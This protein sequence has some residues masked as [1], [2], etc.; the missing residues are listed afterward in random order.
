MIKKFI[1]IILAAIMAFTVFSACDNNP[2]KADTAKEDTKLKIVTTIF[3]QYDFSREIAGDLADLKMLLPPGSESH[4]F[5]PTPQDIID[6]ENCDIFIYTGGESDSW[7]DTILESI[8]APDMKVIALLDVCDAVTEEIVEGMEH[9]ED[10]HSGSP[11]YDEHVWT[12]PKNAITIVEA[13]AEAFAQADAENAE[14]YSNNSSSY[15]EKLKLLD[16]EFREIT[17]NAPIHT[18]I[19]GDRFPFRYFTDEYGLEYYAAFP[20]C[21]TETGASAQTVAFLID[22]VKEKGIPVVLYIEFSNR[23]MADTIAE[24]TGARALQ[25]HSCHSVSPEDMENGASYLTLMKQ[26]AENLKEALY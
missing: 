16:E 14:V 13:I 2:E 8:D 18:L 4:S 7:V 5:E 6:I 26:N 22:T 23:R 21:S 10:D 24:A 9:E 15:I 11:E 17:D 19:F 1:A 12:S 25:L 20:G 3:P